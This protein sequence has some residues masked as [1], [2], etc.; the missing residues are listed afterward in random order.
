MI[1]QINY[2]KL[3][4]SFNTQK[5]MIIGDVMIDSYLWGK[6]DR[7]SPEAPVPVVVVNKRENRLGGAANV[8]LNVQALGATPILCS[9]IG[10]D[11]KGTEFINLLKD[12]NI[13]SEGII[14]SN[15]RPT[16]TKFRIFGNNAQMLR[17]DE[18]VSLPLEKG[19]NEMFIKRVEDLLYTQ[20]INS[21][22]I[23]DYDKGVISKELLDKIIDKL[24]EL[25]IPVAVDPKKRNFAL[26]K[27]ISLFK[28]N[29]KELK[30]G[31]KLENEILSEEE[32]A[33]VTNTLLDKQNIR[34]I[35]TTLSEKGVYLTCNS[36]DRGRLNELIPA[37]I[38]SIA[39]VSGAG[40]TVIS[41]AAICLG[42]DL[43]A[44]DIAFISNMSGG[45]VCEQ[46]GVV[47]VDK[48][49]LLNELKS[50]NKN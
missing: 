8:A 36:R 48:E 41:T 49:V 37:Q 18:E 39:D 24:N 25:N 16:T 10:N 44:V 3:F 43:K 17:V 26:Y 34:I 35:L 23:Q 22:I 50:L 2:D 32:L 27:N 12:N 15:Q 20:A 45:I 14:Q 31:L 46:L 42:L 28:P 33:E 21:V 9:V 1:S 5:V 19:D 30:E 47:P 38:R 6:V 40:D 29:L 7:I 11:V 4:K 13:S